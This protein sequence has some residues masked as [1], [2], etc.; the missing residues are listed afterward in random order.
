MPQDI[1]RNDAEAP[2]AGR[3][4]PRV[5][6]SAGPREPRGTVAAPP[7]AHPDI[8]DLELLAHWLDTRFRIPG[9]GI[10]FGLDSLL[11]L[12]PGVG[13]AAT[14]LPAAYML[15]RAH[16]LGVPRSM[17]ARMGWNVA[18]DLAIGAIPVVGDL[19]DLGF[20]ANRRNVELLRQHFGQPRRTDFHDPVQGSF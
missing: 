11:G 9:T 13:D 5:E 4:R 1:D 18:M 14:T 17:L 12:V 15:Y 3:P 16:R 6:H 2:L 19:F 20:K 8:G 7:G 10:R